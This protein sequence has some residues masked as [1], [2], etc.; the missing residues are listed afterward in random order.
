MEQFVCVQ[1]G[2][3]VQ[4]TEKHRAEPRKPASLVRQLRVKYQPKNIGCRRLRRVDDIPIGILLHTVFDDIGLHTEIHAS[5]RIAQP[6]RTVGL[7]ES[8]AK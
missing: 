4:D 7:P 2:N 6:E 5:V 8:A 3:R 1:D